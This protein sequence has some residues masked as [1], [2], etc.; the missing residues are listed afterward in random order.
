MECGVKPVNSMARSP[1][2]IPYALKE[3]TAWKSLV[4]SNAVGNAM[5]AGKVLCEST[6][7]ATS[8]SDVRGKGVS[9]SRTR[10][11]Q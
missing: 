4:R 8:R 11:F 1:L 5:A 10:L 3:V 9:I 7:S 6:D 2:L